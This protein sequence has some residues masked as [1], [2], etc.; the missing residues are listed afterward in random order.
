MSMGLLSKSI[1]KQ[2]EQYCEAFPGTV[3]SRTTKGH[4][5]IKAPN[6]ETMMIS[7][8]SGSGHKKSSRVESDFR[9]CFG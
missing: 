8:N 7:R 9:R 3:V 4:T 2:V 6:G 5:L 1:R